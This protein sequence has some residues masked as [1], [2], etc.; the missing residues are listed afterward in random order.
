VPFL[1]LSWTCWYSPTT[2]TSTPRASTHAPSDAQARQRAH[3]HVTGARQSTASPRHARPPFDLSSRQ[4]LHHVTLYMLDTLT[5]P[6]ERCRRLHRRL[7]PPRYRELP[8]RSRPRHGLVFTAIKP[9]VTALTAP[10]RLRHRQPLCAPVAASPWTTSSAAPRSRA[11][12]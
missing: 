3:A 6:R 8:S 7:R 10:T 1:S 5:C 12:L 4:Q 11:P 9:C 2:K